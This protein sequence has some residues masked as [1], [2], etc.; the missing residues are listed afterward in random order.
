MKTTSRFAVVAAAGMFM[1]GIA[2]TPAQAADLG[3]DCCA[4]LE[5]RVAELEAT[6]VRKGNRKVS[7]KISGHINRVLMFWDD[8]DEQ[9]V[10]AVDNGGG[11]SRWRFTGSATIR[12]GWS[13][14]YNF[15]WQYTSATTDGSNQV[16]LN[17]RNV[18]GLVLRNAAWYMKWDKFGRVWLGQYSS[19]TDN[20]IYMN[21]VGEGCLGQ[22]CGELYHAPGMFLVRPGVTGNGR[23]IRG[24]SWGQFQPNFD[25]A[26]R[27]DLIRYDTPSIW[28]CVFSASWG[29]NDIWDTAVRCKKELNSVKIIFGIGYI[30]RNGNEAG[31]SRTHLLGVPGA[32]R[33]THERDFIAA[34]SILHDPTGLY[35]NVSYAKREF[36]RAAVFGAIAGVPRNGHTGCTAGGS[37][38]CADVQYLYIQGGIRRRLNDLGKTTFYIDYSRI[39]DARVGNSGTAFAGPNNAVITD[40]ESEV[41]GF[42]IVQNIDNAALQLYLDYKHHELDVQTCTSVSSGVCTNQAIKDLDTLVVGGKIKF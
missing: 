41:W 22:T 17:S 6:T 37:T 5:E 8:G 15:E 10:Y 42:G 20:L 33:A 34:G 35:L 39:E 29:E 3:G 31:E 32:S 27:H 36:D 1:G 38:G 13:A 21:I 18:G 12:P 28:G 25:R 40:A 24:T 26:N 14:G 30:E 4:D 2:L 23:L 7:L 9:D 19:A 11:G 16:S